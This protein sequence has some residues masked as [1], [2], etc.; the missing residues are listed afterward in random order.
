VT[1][2]TSAPIMQASLIDSS[3]SQVTATTLGNCDGI[4]RDGSGRY[5]V[6]AWNTQS[7]YRF[8]NLFSAA[9]VAVVTGLSSPAD[10]YYNLTNDSLACPNAGNN[11]VTFYYMGAPTSVEENSNSTFSVYPNPASGELKI[12]NAKCK[13]NSIEIY[14]MQGRRSLTPTL[15]KGEGVAASVD[16]SALE[17][18]IYFVRLLFSNGEI[19]NLKV[20]I[21]K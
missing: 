8:D 17:S 9:P 10:I 18:G 5:Y 1:W 13:I 6:S 11:T 3:V 16:V 20:A 4:D 19:K 21:E 7:I 2:G 15:S 12:E 14:D